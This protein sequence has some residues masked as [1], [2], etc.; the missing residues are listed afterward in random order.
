V[1]HDF[2]DYCAASVWFKAVGS[3]PRK[4]FAVYIRFW[5]LIS[6]HDYATRYKNIGSVAFLM[7]LLRQSLI[8]QDFP[9]VKSLE[10]QHL[11]K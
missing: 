2:E 1:Y 11:P 10:K 6:A 5:S 4:V 7:I 3:F 9:L 8:L